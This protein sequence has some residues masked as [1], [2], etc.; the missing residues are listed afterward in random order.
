MA[1]GKP[2]KKTPQPLSQPMSDKAMQAVRVIEDKISNLNKKTE[3]IEDNILKI[4]Q[5]QNIEIKSMHEHVL[6]L[7]K[8]VS[9]L[10]KTIVEMAADLKHF[11]RRER[12]ETMQKYLDLWNPVS[13][14]T[15]KEVEELVNEKLREKK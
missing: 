1:L 2:N 9:L 3:V 15:H 14:A 5:R 6:S 8:Q 11:A 7:E 4:N 13:F 12:V 10:R